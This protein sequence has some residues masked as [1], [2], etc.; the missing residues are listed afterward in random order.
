[1]ATALDFRCS[2]VPARKVGAHRPIVLRAADLPVFRLRR[3]QKP[4]VGAGQAGRTRP[5][6]GVQSTQYDRRGGCGADEIEPV[7]RRHARR[8]TNFRVVYVEVSGSPTV[9]I[10][11]VRIVVSSRYETAAFHRFLIPGDPALT[12]GCVKGGEAITW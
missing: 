9:V 5:I 11:V 10:V 6:L 12:I 4:D 1:M 3:S 2:Y 7:I 8:D